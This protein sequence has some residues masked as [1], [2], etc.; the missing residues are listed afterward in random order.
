MPRQSLHVLA[1][2]HS[3]G[4][5]GAVVDLSAKSSADLNA[6]LLEVLGLQSPGS[7][8]STRSAIGQ[9]RLRLPELGISN[10]DLANIVA[11]QA[12]ARGLSITFDSRDG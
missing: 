4:E 5:N 2:R 3:G 11:D 7:I 1:G 8:V 12:I 9:L 10:E 6:A